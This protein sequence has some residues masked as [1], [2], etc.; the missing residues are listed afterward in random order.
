[1]ISTMNQH[2]STDQS[3]LLSI[4]VGMPQTLTD[5]N[6]PDPDKASWTT[7][8]YK[9]PIE[10]WA[11]VS[12]LNI[13][14]DGQ[15]DQVHH[16]GVDKAILAYSADHFETWQSELDGR[17]ALEINF[18]LTMSFSKSPNQ[19]SLAGNLD[20]AGIWKNFLNAWFKRRDAAGIAEFFKQ[21]PS[22]QV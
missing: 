16:G 13:D 12:S 3:V 15:A 11:N 8:F 6:E 18:K 2:E 20:D 21:E 9:S 22:N 10:G 19:D 1:M 4:Q 17:F 14:G 5:Q 7:G